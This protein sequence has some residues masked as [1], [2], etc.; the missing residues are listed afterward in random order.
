VTGSEWISL[1]TFLFLLY[2]KPNIATSYT[3]TV[4]KADSMYVC[5]NT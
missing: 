5:K 4:C 2:M 3:F 1:H